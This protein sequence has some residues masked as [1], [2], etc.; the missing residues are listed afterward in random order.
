MDNLQEKLKKLAVNVQEMFE[1]PVC[2]G[3]MDSTLKLCKNGHGVCNLCAK[4][5]TQCPKCKEEYVPELHQNTLLGQVLECMPKLCPYSGKG[6]GAVVFDQEHQTYCEYRPT[7]CLNDFCNWEGCVKDLIGHVKTCGKG[8]ALSETS[9]DREVPRAYSFDLNESESY[10]TPIIC[11]N[12]VFWKY[13]LRDCS[14]KC[15]LHE[16]YTV[17]TS[18]PSCDY[19]LVVKFEKGKLKFEHACKATAYNSNQ[20]ENENRTGLIIPDCEMLKFLEPG[21]NN[22]F[23][24]TLKLVKEDLS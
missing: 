18:K 7:E 23:E 8:N 14:T 19:Y 17:P 9:L 4:K 10:F 22:K 5:V 1:C 2:F 13:F 16:L 20:N 15:I 21:S 12:Q 3:A 11:Q 24:F 6:C